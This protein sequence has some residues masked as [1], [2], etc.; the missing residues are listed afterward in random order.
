MAEPK[1]KITGGGPAARKDESASGVRRPFASSNQAKPAW[2]NAGPPSGIDPNQSGNRPITRCGDGDH[3][4]SIRWTGGSSIWLRNSLIAGAVKGSVIHFSATPVGESDQRP[5]KPGRVGPVGVNGRV[6]HAAAGHRLKVNGGIGNAQGLVGDPGRVGKR[7]ADHDGLSG[8]VPLADRVEDHR[9]VLLHQL[10]IQDD[11]QPLLRVPQVR[12]VRHRGVFV[13]RQG[14]DELE[15]V[16]RRHIA[17]RFGRDH[18]HAVPALA[19]R[20][21]DPDKRVN[22]AMTTDGDE[23]KVGHVG[24][25]ARKE[26]LSPSGCPISL[27]IPENEA[28]AGTRLGH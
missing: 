24:V 1:L 18:R 15:S 27:S 16:P 8:L 26:P 20:L 13:G 9:H 4:I 25:Q 23:K 14:T 6:A 11:L 3:F 10:A 12:V 2:R 17:K 22:I 19:Q 28:R 5:R 7:A 21:P